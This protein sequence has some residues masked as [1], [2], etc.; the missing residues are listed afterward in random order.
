MYN[1]YPN[2]WEHLY[3]TAVSQHGQFIT[4][5]KGSRLD[6]TEDRAQLPEDKTVQELGDEKEGI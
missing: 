1:I 4:V 3:R 5:E 6:V 2:T